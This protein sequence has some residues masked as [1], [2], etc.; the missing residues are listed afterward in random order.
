[1]ILCVQL[2]EYTERLPLGV[3]FTQKGSPKCT[4]ILSRIY[5]IGQKDEHLITL[6]QKVY[7]LP[8]MFGSEM[9]TRL[10]QK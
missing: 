6:E 7:N 4:E 3:L 9:R 1:M 5:L 2:K 10:V 8:K